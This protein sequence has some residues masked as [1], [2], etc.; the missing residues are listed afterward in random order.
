MDGLGNHGIHEHLGLRGETEEYYQLQ[1]EQHQHAQHFQGHAHN[2]LHGLVNDPFLPSYHDDTCLD[3]GP[4]HTHTHGP[5]KSHQQTM[6][7]AHHG[8]SMSMAA[9]STNNFST[10][11]TPDINVFGPFVSN[12]TIGVTPESNMTFDHH[13]A[14]SVDWMTAYQEQQ[15]QQ[16]M[17]YQEEQLQ[18]SSPAMPSN[19]SDC[20]ESDSCA[21][22]CPDSRCEQGVACNNKDCAESPC[23][24][25]FSDCDDPECEGD[26]CSEPDCLAL[27]GP[28][29][30][31]AESL[32]SL[33]S[34]PAQSSSQ[35]PS[36]PFSGQGTPHGLSAHLTMQSVNIGGLSE[37]P[38]F[39]MA[40]GD[41]YCSSS[42]RHGIP[43]DG[44][45]MPHAYASQVYTNGSI[46]LND[47]NNNMDNLNQFIIHALEHHVPGPHPDRCLGPCY[48]T[49]NGLVFE[50]CP[51]PMDS[52]FHPGQRGFCTDNSTQ[53]EC[54]APLHSEPGAFLDHIREMHPMTI[55]Q[56][57]MEAVSQQTVWPSSRG[58]L[59]AQK[60]ISRRSP[61]DMSSPTLSS[62]SGTPM[63]AETPV[64][65]DT[66]IGQACTCKWKVSD[67]QICGLRLPNDEALQKHCKEI[68]LSAMAKQAKGFPC[69]WSTC[70]RDTT[71]NQKSKLERHMQTHTG[72]KPVKCEVCHA[73]LSAKQ[74]LAQ[75][76][77]IHT[78]EKPWKCN[79]P[80]CTQSFKQ[81]SA[82]TMHKRTHT[83]EKPLSCEICGKKFGESSNLSKHRKTHNVKG[84]FTCEVCGK[85]FHRLDQMRRHMRVHENKD[86]DTQHGNGS[87]G[88]VISGRVEK[89]TK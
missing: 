43:S 60:S 38:N 70:P 40:H 32:I 35:P 77:R 55:E 59:P 75:H 41:F 48:D 68:H 86:K 83:G 85:D 80:D 81:Q 69:L 63:S 29:L 54:N 4:G 13:N 53:G 28:S 7:Q 15:Q 89:N 72:Y 20:D 8:R 31:A 46:D 2:H 27:D 16:L 65:P 64:T 49:V 44:L 66:D 45:P 12:Y 62:A 1:M 57:M 47:L 39:N 37:T 9:I 17:G 24:S 87:M 10:P 74:S 79:F 26:V 5:T 14:M 34:R 82:L 51:L 56:H 6:N 84:Q 76:M 22:Q 19:H 3:L 58:T 88:R 23:L 21:M 52:H 42:A 36:Q 78:G 71:F 67:D 30:K 61:L 73:A 50:K 33:E 18:Q 25:S 11:H